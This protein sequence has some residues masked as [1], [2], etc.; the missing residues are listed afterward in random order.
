MAGAREHDL[1]APRVFECLLLYA[2]GADNILAL[3]AFG[4]EEGER[5]VHLT[6][7]ASGSCS[8][9][10]RASAGPRPAHKHFGAHRMCGEVGVV[11]HFIVPRFV[12]K[13]CECG[14]ERNT[15]LVFESARDK[16]GQESGEAVLVP[17]QT[18]LTASRAARY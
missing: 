18:R 15:K 11:E 14:G 9:R 13:L 10:A 17:W 6:G 1:P 2:G 5:V 8:A 4:G 7:V 3:H 16:K 12:E